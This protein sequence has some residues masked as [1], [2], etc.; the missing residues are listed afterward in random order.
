MGAQLLPACR[1]SRH[2]QN[3]AHGSR[4]PR[5]LLPRYR[6]ASE[7]QQVP[8]QQKQQSQSS[9]KTKQTEQP[10][11]SQWCHK[12]WCQRRQRDRGLSWLQWKSVLTRCSALFRKEAEGRSY[13]D[14]CWL[15]WWVICQGQS[16][17]VLGCIY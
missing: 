11:W 16:V 15:T 9:C 6:G 3:V 12:E 4:P 8:Q 13:C 5:Y 2:Q 14:A 10:V 17:C 7:Q 1:A